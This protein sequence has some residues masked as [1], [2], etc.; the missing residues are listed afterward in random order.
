MEKEQAKQVREIPV[1]TDQKEW[2]VLEK[3]K[4]IDKYI[5]PGLFTDGAVTYR[6]EYVMQNTVT[7]ELKRI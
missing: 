4:V 1:E 5:R 2:I 6:Y 7:G 3:Q